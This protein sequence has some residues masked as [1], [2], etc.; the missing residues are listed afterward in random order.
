VS[1]SFPDE[2]Q[3]RFALSQ[4]DRFLEVLAAAVWHI[5]GRVRQRGEGKS[6]SKVKSRRSEL[7]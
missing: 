2:G 6:S 4:A 1:F 7:E 3:E 5:D